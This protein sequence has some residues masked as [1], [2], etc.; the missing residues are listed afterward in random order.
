VTEATTA[1]T[2]TVASMSS[3][4]EQLSAS[5]SEIADQASRA[6]TVAAQGVEAADVTSAA[7]SQLNSASSEISDIV[8]SITSIAQQT[9]LL[10][11]NATIES[12]R[13][14]EAG[15]GFAVVATE[16]KQLA[17][18]TA[19]AT[20]DVT[21]KI[22]AIQATALR[23]TGAIEEINGIISNVHQRQATIAAAV[24][25]QTAVTREVSKAVH[26]VADGALLINRSMEGISATASETDRGAGSAHA[27]AVEL[28]QLA[29][30]VQGLVASFHH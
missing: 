2:T 23:V 21:G 7:L 29:T 30:Q 24:E 12:A 5:I 19:R 20:G 11:L 4:T 8:K 6:S 15:K 25:E 18:E 13:A 1:M 3:A 16:V 26:D 17:T 9:N 27:S 28:S 22:E 14:G 10:A